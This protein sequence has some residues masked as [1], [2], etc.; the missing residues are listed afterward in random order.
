MAAVGSI[1][2]GLLELTCWTPLSDLGLET[3]PIEDSS[4]GLTDR[5]RTHTRRC[6][7]S[8]SARASAACCVSWREHRAPKRKVVLQVVLRA[9]KWCSEGG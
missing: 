5:M 7:P 2:P 1:V 9:P 4:L 6:N 3:N 8:S